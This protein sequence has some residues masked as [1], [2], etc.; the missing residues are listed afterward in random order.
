MLE[1]HKMNDFKDVDN[2]ENINNHHRRAHFIII[3][4][5]SLVFTP[6]K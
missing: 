6:W 2:M 1:K 4:N 3:S 5:G